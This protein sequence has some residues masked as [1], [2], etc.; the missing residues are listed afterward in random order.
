MQQ[1]ALLF[2]F[3]QIRN[4]FNIAASWIVFPGLSLLFLW[5]ALMI[6]HTIITLFV[7]SGTGGGATVRAKSEKGRKK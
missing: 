3:G 4:M 1:E 6:L 2:V 5:A 7:P